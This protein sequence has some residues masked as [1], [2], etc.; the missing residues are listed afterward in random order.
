MRYE[1][2]ADLE[3]AEMAFFTVTTYHSN[4]VPDECTSSERIH[5]Q[6]IRVD[7]FTRRNEVTL[8]KR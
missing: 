4:H 6:W 8:A 2:A 7:L 3:R 1:L 5:L